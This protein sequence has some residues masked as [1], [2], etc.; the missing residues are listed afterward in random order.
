MWI[1]K[2]QIGSKL[3]LLQYLIRINKE[4]YDFPQEYVYK[5]NKQPYKGI[6]FKLQQCCCI[7]DNYTCQPDNHD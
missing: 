4:I 5:F 1:F 3:I 7:P 2:M 6:K